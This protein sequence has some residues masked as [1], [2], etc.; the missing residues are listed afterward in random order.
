M[1]VGDSTGNVYTGQEG[2][3]KAFILTP[4]EDLQTPLTN[5]LAQEA[6]NKKPKAT[7]QDLAKKLKEGEENL[8]YRHHAQL[9]DEMDNI[10]NYYDELV[11]A[12]LDPFNDS[13]RP[14][15]EFR[16]A[17]GDLEKKFNYSTQIKELY[18]KDK[19]Q[20]QTN[21]GKMTDAGRDRTFGWYDTHD[22]NEAIANGELP[23]VLEWEDPEF[24][25]QEAAKSAAAGISNN[26]TSLDPAQ[27]QVQY[28]NIA[29][30]MLANSELASEVDQVLDNMSDDAKK[31]LKEKADQLGVTPQQYYLSNFVKS[32]K[33]DA[34]VDFE[35][36]SKA[37]MP[38]LDLDFGSY[39]NL[40]KT[41][42]SSIKELSLDKAMRAA[43]TSLEVNPSIRKSLMG[44]TYTKYSKKPGKSPV[45]IGEGV[46]K[47]KES[48][49]EMVANYWVNMAAMEVKDKV[50]YDE[51]DYNAYGFKGYKD[52][53][54]DKDLWWQ[55]LNY[56]VEK[57]NGQELS[58]EERLTGQKAAIAYAAG[59]ELTPALPGW[60]IID[61]GAASIANT[62]EGG[63]VKYY[64]FK[65]NLLEGYSIDRMADTGRIH[66]PLAK[67]V[68]VEGKTGKKEKKIEYRVV[69]A[70]LGSEELLSA[71]A[72]Q[73]YNYGLKESQMPFK[74]TFELQINNNRSG[75]GFSRGSQGLSTDTKEQVKLG[76]E[77]EVRQ[78]DANQMVEDV[79]TGEGFNPFTV[80]DKP[81][82]N[83]N[84]SPIDNWD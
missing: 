59:N 2:F 63:A 29:G 14:S 7:P 21:G 54:K 9:Q 30:G 45:A 60:K 73:Q 67:E 4:Q 31:V 51:N 6:A 41:T 1:A 62:K 20:Y 19:Q 23:P 22:I 49:A 33:A 34:P 58:D 65:G 77:G 56:N 8:F 57:F 18:A 5:L 75:G 24:D 3:D 55:F 71:E 78:K 38:S 32:Y 15:Q 47:D 16:N 28:N 48:A 61:Y 70:D 76:G 66:I 36:W 68:T 79:L 50:E 81:T 12:G 44:R 69:V 10:T 72:F 83:N 82:D 13:G 40:D 39:E 17:M 52:L 37:N 84:G 25:L 53:E 27:Q 43:T 80:V 46:V 11:R 74:K 35:A 42:T 26:I 64:D